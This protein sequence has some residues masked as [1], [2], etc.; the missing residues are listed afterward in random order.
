ME[1]EREQE[2]SFVSTLLEKNRYCHPVRCI[3]SADRNWR[4]QVTSSSCKT[5]WRRPDVVVPRGEQN[6]KDGVGS[7]WNTDAGGD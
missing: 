3:I 6:T 4:L 1:R 7:D 2:E 5:T